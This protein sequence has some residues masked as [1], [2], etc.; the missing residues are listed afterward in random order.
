MSDSTYARPVRSPLVLAAAVLVAVAAVT[1]CSSSSDSPQ[2][3]G[4]STAPAAT[5]TE[6]GPQIDVRMVADSEVPDG[7]AELLDQQPGIQVS[8]HLSADGAT[9]A[10]LDESV[11]A[12]LAEQ[13]DVLVYSGGTNDLATGPLQMLEGLKERLTRW[14]AQTCVVMAVPVF[15]YERGTDEEVAKR[16]AGTRILEEG[17]ASTGAKVAS[18]LDVALAM[19]DEGKDFFAEGE[20]GDLHPGPIAYPGIAESIAE[21]VRACAAAS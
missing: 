12:A 17:A 5:T 21:Q 19:D 7:V 3:S 20:L 13:P 1:S 18:Y 9:M 4:S 14:G 16:T 11:E 2:A 15:R 6:S 8:S 10:Q